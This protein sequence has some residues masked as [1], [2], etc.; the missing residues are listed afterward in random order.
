MHVNSNT[1]LRVTP[2]LKY[3]VSKKHDQKSTTHWGL[4]IKTQAHNK[5]QIF[6]VQ[7]N[8]TQVAALEKLLGICNNI[9]T[10]Y[11]PG[12][13]SITPSALGAMLEQA[14]QN[15][16]AVTDAQ[17]AYTLA[18]NARKEAY[19]AL[20]GF[21][22]QLVRSALGHSVSEED[23]RDLKMLRAKFYP[24]IRSKKPPAPASGQSQGS[25]N[26]EKS[27]PAFIRSF[28]V[29]AGYFASIVSIVE[30]LPNFRPNE[31]DLGVEGLKAKL[32]DLKAKSSAVAK[33]ANDLATARIN[34]DK[35]FYGR[36]GIHQTGMTV[37]EYIRSVTGIRSANAR[38]AGKVRFA[39]KR[40]R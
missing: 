18:V 13:A 11:N 20:P 12:N 30:R 3:I 9:G 16:K 22:T 8:F 14:Q 15:A 32:A 19:A 10:R 29:K 6:M 1:V 35:V 40:I 26:A 34:R 4:R 27:T 31:A 2:S 33:A 23:A 25:G 37:K 38:E 21:V 39:R 17:S 36:G 28:D 5:A 7:N 24:A